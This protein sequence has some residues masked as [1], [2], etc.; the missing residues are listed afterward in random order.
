VPASRSSTWRPVELSK[1]ALPRGRRTRPAGRSPRSRRGARS[2]RGC[3]PASCQNPM[4]GSSQTFSSGTPWA[5]A[6]DSRSLQERPLRRRRP[7][8]RRGSTCIV[9]RL[10][11]HVHED[12]TRRRPSAVTVASSGSKRKAATVVDDRR[13]PASS[14]AARKPQ[15]FVVS[16]EMPGAVGRVAPRSPGIDAPAAPRR[17]RRARP[18]GRGSTRPPMSRMSA[19][20]G[21]A[22]HGRG[23]IAASASRKQPPRPRNESG[24]TLTM[25]MTSGSTGRI[26]RRYGP[27]LGGFLGRAWGMAAGRGRRSRAGCGRGLPGALSAA[28]ASSSGPK[29]DS[30]VSPWKAGARTGLPRSSRGAAGCRRPT[31]QVPADDR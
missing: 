27:F 22:A 12:A 15:L 14:G 19:P 1:E 17:P 11:Q 5:T 10:A 18:P 9:R 3:A 6:N 4:P 16:M 26:V 2:A 24:V 7:R 29:T 21:R 30:S 23:A 31:V 28:R 13:L 8:R 25:P 20:L